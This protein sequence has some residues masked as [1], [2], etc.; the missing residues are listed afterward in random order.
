M[1]ASS[2]PSPMPQANPS[3][4][5]G[6]GDAAAHD[7]GRT[8]RRP[9]AVEPASDV[10]VREFAGAVFGALAHLDR[11]FTRTVDILF[12]RPGALTREYFAGDRDRYTPPLHLFFIANV[13]FFFIGPSLGLFAFNLDAYMRTAA[14]AALIQRELVHLGLPLEVYRERFNAYLQF[15]QPAFIFV[16]VPLFALVL[17]LL[18]RRRGFSRQ[19]V[20]SLHFFSW[21]LLA[22]PA[23]A[24]ACRIL[25]APFALIG[26]ARHAAPPLGLAIAAIALF[27]LAVIGYLIVSFRTTF[28][29]T[30]WRA[31]LDG[32]LATAALLLLI[33]LYAHFLFYTTFLRLHY[34]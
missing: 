23:F 19:L 3:D 27:L 18:G 22:A 9:E 34:A 13:V 30:R 12:R 16:L 20:C 8:R 26:P 10:S 32:V 17:L 7:Q 6:A 28:G 11:R 4:S 14:Y 24:L 5:P 25:Y 33:V 29:I 21:L 2:M 1:A 31:A 15:R